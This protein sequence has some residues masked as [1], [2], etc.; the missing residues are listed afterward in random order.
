MKNKNILSGL[1][2]LFIGITL[3]LTTLGYIEKKALSKLVSFWP[4]LLILIGLEIIYRSTRIKF[5][6]FISP[7]L[8]VAV[9]TFVI[10]SNCNFGNLKFDS[11]SK[12]KERIAHIEESLFEN[13]SSADIRLKHSWGTLTITG[14]TTSLLDGYFSYFNFRPKVSLGLKLMPDSSY[15][16]F[17]EIISM[18][19]RVY[20]RK[21][22]FNK[23]IIKR[24]SQ[25]NLYLNDKIPLDLSI[26]SKSSKLYF[27][28]SEIKL[29][30]L[31]LNLGFGTVNLILGR[32]VED[33]NI[34]IKAGIFN[35]NVLVPKDSGVK[36]QL[37]S[38][39]CKTNIRS[40]KY[41]KEGKNTF[42][43]PNFY[44]AK[45]KILVKVSSG[46]GL[47]TFKKQ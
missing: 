2:V 12:I 25:W 17:Y 33:T 30:N 6:K 18:D 16:Q 20:Q 13:V 29:K 23:S 41:I 5:I 44:N 46:A 14:K 40:L 1:I 9:F 45:N 22:L 32:E 24:P 8:I 34:R 10:F 36:V 4:V 43:S 15:R 35:M 27:D 21:Y 3:L 39:F 31:N 19:E 38:G 37:L 47:I 26:S 11:S 42:V 7:V 28:F